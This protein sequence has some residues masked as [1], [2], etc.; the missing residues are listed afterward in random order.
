MKFSIIITGPWTAW[1]N[2]L[3]ESARQ[4]YPESQ[5]IFSTWSDQDLKNCSQVDNLLVNDVSLMTNCNNHQHFSNVFFS[6]K[7]GLQIAEEA[8]TI[9]LRSDLK[10]VSPSLKDYMNYR[11]DKNC[12]K[13]CIFKEKIRCVNLGSLMHRG[14]AFYFAD[15]CQSGLTEDLIKF[16]DVELLPKDMKKIQYLMP[17][18]TNPHELGNEHAVPLMSIKKYLNYTF[19]SPNFFCENERKFHDDVLINNFVLLDMMNE[20]GLIWKKH[21]NYGMGSDVLYYDRLFQSTFP[22][23]GNM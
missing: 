5:L 13:V 8:Y 18:S 10:I 6:C 7:A 2:D 15:V 9:R 20:Y 21:P 19:M 14:Y 12:K 1:T 3:I 4:H 22:I 16:F 11:L 17:N 23:V